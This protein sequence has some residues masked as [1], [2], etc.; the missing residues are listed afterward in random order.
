MWETEYRASQMNYRRPRL[1]Y[2][3]EL[4]EAQRNPGEGLNSQKLDLWHTDA[5]QLG[6]MLMLATAMV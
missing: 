4:I 1:A 6:I 2:F 5:D 3:G